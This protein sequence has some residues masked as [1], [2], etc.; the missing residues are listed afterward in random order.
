MDIIIKDTKI[1][2][3][4]EP[5]TIRFGLPKHK[6]DFIIRQN[7][8]LAENTMKNEIVQIYYCPNIYIYVISRYKHGNDIPKHRNQLNK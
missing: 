2:I 7:D 1:M 3:M 6:S 5:K 8:F 4:T